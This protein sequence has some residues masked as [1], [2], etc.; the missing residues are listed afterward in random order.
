MSKKEWLDD[1]QAQLGYKFKKPDLLFQAFTRKTYALENG[2]ADNEILEFVGDR[3][4]DIIVTKVLMDE[5]GYF[6]EDTEDYDQREDD[7]EFFSNLSEGE[8]TELKKRLVQKRTLADRIDR[9]G[10]N[11]YLIL[12]KGDEQ[13][14]IQKKASVKE[15]LFEAI[16]G[17]VTIDSNWNFE[18]I[19]EV[20]NLML[21]PKEELKDE[22]SINYVSLVHDWYVSFYGELPKFECK[23]NPGWENMMAVGNTTGRYICETTLGPYETKGW[24]SYPDI[25]VTHPGQSFWGFGNS[26]SE[27]RRDLCYKIYDYIKKNGLLTTMRDE[28]DN[29]NKDEAINQ[30]EILARRGYFS[31]PIYSFKEVY[32]KDGNPIWN[33]KCQIEEYSVTMNAKASSKKEAKKKAAFKMLK[34]VLESEG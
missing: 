5:Y 30:L 6:T 18:E 25:M 16:I 29:P 28:I 14:N 26:K 3:A 31:I 32:D 13:N 4:L 1:I 22:E 27:A 20:V 11:K 21:D 10:W 8:L 34:Y 19:E 12:G 17:A 9:L 24:G 23:L 33:A 15:D 2:G 7:N